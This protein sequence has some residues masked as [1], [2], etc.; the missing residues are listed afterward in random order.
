MD[1]AD[2]LVPVHRYKAAASKGWRPDDRCVVLWVEDGADGIKFD[3]W[4]HGVVDSVTNHTGQWQGLP[5]NALIVEYYNVA[6]PA[7]NIT[8]QLLL[9]AT[10]RRRHAQDSRWCWRRQRRGRVLLLSSHSR[11]RRSLRH[12]GHRPGDTGA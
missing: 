12:R 3:N 8:A 5:W 11:R 9:G 7:D 4:W 6:N 10:R 2:F 1:D